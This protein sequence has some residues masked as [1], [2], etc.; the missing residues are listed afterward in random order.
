MSQSIQTLLNEAHKYLGVRQYSAI[1]HYLVQKYNSIRPLPV[2]YQVTLDDSW[3]DLFVTVIADLVGLSDLIGRECGVQRHVQIF[4]DKGIWLGR[5]YPKVGDIVVFDWEGTGWAD[6]IGF[7]A[8]VDGHRITTIEGNSNQVVAKNSFVWNDWR[9]M[10]YARPQY[11]LKDQEQPNLDFVLNYQGV[12]LPQHILNHLQ[13]LAQAHQINLEFLIIMLHF[14]G[15]WGASRVAKLNNNWAGITYVIPNSLNPHIKKTKGSLRPSSEGG[16]YFKY[17]S[18]EDFLEDW[19][20]LL[21]RLYKVQGNK[22]FEESVKGLFRVGGAKYDYA[23]I[24]YHQYLLRMIARREA[25]KTANPKMD[26]ILLKSDTPAPKKSIDHIAKEVIRGLWSTGRER[27]K[28]LKQAGYN[29]QAVQSRVN[30]LM[31]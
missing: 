9:I 19:I 31:N 12:K 22:S 7:V 5:Q 11:H 28:R 6:H 2:G 20:Y 18:V 23:A 21:C 10:G 29:A 16:H 27:F 30:Q 8:Q 4:K 1:H 13:Q 3:C 17:D 26:E 14:E 25:I 15:V 24:G